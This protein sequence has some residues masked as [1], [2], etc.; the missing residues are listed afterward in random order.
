MSE[1]DFWVVPPEF[2]L[3]Q[4]FSCL[5]CFSLKALNNRTTPFSFAGRACLDHLLST[6]GLKSNTL[7][8]LS[9]LWLLLPSFFPPLAMASSI[10]MLV[11]LF[12]SSAPQALRS[13]YNPYLR[14]PPLKKVSQLRHVLFLA[15]NNMRHIFFWGGVGGIIPNKPPPLFKI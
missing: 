7:L 12:C 11:S 10:Q 1:C 9:S 8:F 15:N 2:T 3:K 6:W 5:F 14:T 13:F 4:I